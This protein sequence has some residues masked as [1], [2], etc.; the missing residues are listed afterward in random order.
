[1][2]FR[3]A[4]TD[5]REDW[6]RRFSLT[7]TNMCW[8]V[9]LSLPCLPR[10]VF[11]PKSSDVDNKWETCEIPS[12]LTPVDAVQLRLQ[13]TH[14]SNMLRPS[15]VYHEMYTSFSEMYPC[16]ASDG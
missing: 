2:E 8:W 15:L 6:F 11:I 9:A 3:T 12:G 5:V 10:T 1:M 14:H 7:H 16:Q 4:F 13:D